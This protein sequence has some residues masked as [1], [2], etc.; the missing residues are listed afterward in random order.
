MSSAKGTGCS[1]PATTTA[2]TASM[3]RPRWSSRSIRRDRA[4]SSRRTM[5]SA[6][7]STFATLPIATYGPAGSAPST[8][9]RARRA[10]GSWRI[11]RA[12]APTPSIHA[13]PMSPS[14]APAKGPRSIPTAVPSSPRRLGCAT[15]R[16]SVRSMR[17][18][19]LR[20][21]QRLGYRPGARISSWTPVVKLAPQLQINNKIEI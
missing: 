15:A 9:A 6:R 5:A 2:R 8:P 21:G 11:W 13:P 20:R 17:R 14:P 16:R 10:T 19:G 18:W 4:L 1:S 3:A 7:C 12:F